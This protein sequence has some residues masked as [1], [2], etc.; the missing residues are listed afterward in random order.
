MIIFKVCAM[1]SQL[2]RSKPFTEVCYYQ[3]YK[4]GSVH[5]MNISAAINYMHLELM[6]LQEC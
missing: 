6:V 5:F 1:F 4:S 3:A 2:Y